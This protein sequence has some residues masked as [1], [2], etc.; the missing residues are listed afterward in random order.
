MKPNNPP[1]FPNIEPLKANET[2]ESEKS[3]SKL[4]AWLHLKVVDAE[5]TFNT[6]KQLAATWRT[7]TD[8][9]WKAAGQMH[10]STA[11][12]T[13]KKAARLK[14]AE[15]HERIAGQLWREVTMFRAVL[16][17]LAAHKEPPK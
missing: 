8:D 3:Y 6:R 17:A 1:A 9:E 5:K 15:M 11:G 2:G 10:I 7:G 14:E 13:L 16:T 4:L 12:K